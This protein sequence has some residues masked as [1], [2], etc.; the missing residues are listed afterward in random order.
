MFFSGGRIICSKIFLVLKKLFWGGR[1]LREISETWPRVAPA[2]PGIL[3]GT[4][5]SKMLIFAQGTY[6]EIIL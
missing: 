6:L 3:Q 2:W 4:L 5:P 1:F